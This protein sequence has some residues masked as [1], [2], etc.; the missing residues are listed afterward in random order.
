MFRSRLGPVTRARSTFASFG[1]PAQQR[2]PIVADFELSGRASPFAQRATSSPATALPPRSTPSSRACPR[3]HVEV[4]HSHG[5]PCISSTPNALLHACRSPVGRL[6]ARSTETPVSHTLDWYV[7]PYSY[8]ALSGPLHAR[9]H[10]SSL[11]RRLPF[12]SQRCCAS[13]RVTFVVG[14]AP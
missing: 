2:S 3:P 8:V 9:S 12:A 1:G 6:A 5:P 4:V 10:S 13:S 7:S 14:M 11:H